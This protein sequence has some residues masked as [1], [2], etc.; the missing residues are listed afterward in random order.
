MITYMWNKDRELIKSSSISLHRG[1]LNVG[2]LNFL[3]PNMVDGVDVTEIPLFIRYTL[4][5]GD[6]YVE[7]ITEVEYLDDKKVNK[8][9]L[10]ISEEMTSVSGKIEFDLR[11]ETIPEEPDPDDPDTEEEP[12][13]RIFSGVSYLDIIPNSHFYVLKTK[14]AEAEEPVNPNPGTGSSTP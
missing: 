6:T 3:I 13:T 12:I 11:F 2:E 7:Q 1:D 10:E 8:Y 5:N 9:T 4:P 14:K